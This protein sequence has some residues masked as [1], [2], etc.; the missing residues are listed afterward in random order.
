MKVT[1]QHYRRDGCCV[2]VEL[3]LLS[4]VPVVW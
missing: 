2:I 4:F 3:G 1:K